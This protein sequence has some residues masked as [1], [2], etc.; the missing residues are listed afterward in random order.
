MTSKEGPAK[1]A[2]CV[3]SNASLP[4]IIEIIL[5]MRFGAHLPKLVISVYF[6]CTRC[7]RVIIKDAGLDKNIVVRRQKGCKSRVYPVLEGRVNTGREDGRYGS[8]EITRLNER[9]LKSATASVPTSS[10]PCFKTK[11]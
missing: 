4:I 2:Q 3:T 9:D 11:S 1:P 8:L 6:Q 7:E 10:C 5:A